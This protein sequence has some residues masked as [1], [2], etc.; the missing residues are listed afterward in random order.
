MEIWT[1]AIDA[2]ADGLR[3]GITLYDPDIIVLGGGLAQAGAALLDPLA[4][5]V[6][7]R[8]T[9]QTMPLLVRAELGDEAGCLGAAQL[10]IDLLTVAESDRG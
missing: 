9:F 10:A 4:S 6:R 2:L 5:A 8:L 7:G 1:D 3:I